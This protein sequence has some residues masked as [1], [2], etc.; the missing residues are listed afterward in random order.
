[1]NVEYGHHLKKFIVLE[2]V[3][4]YM[5]VYI[6]HVHVYIVHACMH[7]TT[8]FVLWPGWQQQPAPLD[9]LFCEE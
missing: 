9:S 1:M 5:Y 7:S 6:I 8:Y 3:T 2:H 4:L